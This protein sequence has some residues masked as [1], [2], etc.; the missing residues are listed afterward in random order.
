VVTEFENVNK[1]QFRT[2]QKQ[3]KLKG[4]LNPNYLNLTTNR[5]KFYL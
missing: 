4:T 5:K 3:L 1:V 2:T